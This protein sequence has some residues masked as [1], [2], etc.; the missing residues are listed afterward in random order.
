VSKHPSTE[1]CEILLE[2]IREIQALFLEDSGQYDHTDLT[3]AESVLAD[4]Y[5]ALKCW[6]EIIWFWS[7]FNEVLIDFHIKKYST[8]LNKLINQFNQDY[9]SKNDIEN[10]APQ[11]NKVLEGKQNKSFWQGWTIFNKNNE[12]NNENEKEEKFDTSGTSGQNDDSVEEVIPQVD[13]IDCTLITNRIEELQN[14]KAVDKFDAEIE[15]FFLIS[16]FNHVQKNKLI[17]K[18]NNAFEDL[19]NANHSISL[20]LEITH[21]QYENVLDIKHFKAI[22]VNNSPHMNSPDDSNVPDEKKE[23]DNSGNLKSTQPGWFSLT[24]NASK[25]ILE[26]Q[27]YQKVNLCFNSLSR[28]SDKNFTWEKIDEILEKVEF[29]KIPL[30]RTDSPSSSIN[31]TGVTNQEKFTVQQVVYWNPVETLLSR[32]KKL[33]SVYKELCSARE[34]LNHAENNQKLLKTNTESQ[35]KIATIDQTVNTLESQFM[36]LKDSFKALCKISP[37]KNYNCLFNTEKNETEQ[38]ARNMQKDIQELNK[39]FTALQNQNDQLLTRYRSLKN[40]NEIKKN[41]K[42]EQE[43][44]KKEIENVK[45]EI[46]GLCGK[47]IDLEIELKNKKNSSTKNNSENN[48]LNKMKSNSEDVLRKEIK[49]LEEEIKYKK[50]EHQFK[51]QEKVACI[52]YAELTTTLDTPMVKTFSPF[53]T[54]IQ[55]IEKLVGSTINADKLIDYIQELKKKSQALKGFL[56]KIKDEIMLLYKDSMT[57]LKKLCKR[58]EENF[59]AIFTL[60]EKSLGQ[61]KELSNQCDKLLAQQD[62]LYRMTRQRIQQWEEY[63]SIVDQTIELIS[64]TALQSIE[65]SILGIKG[66]REYFTQCLQDTLGQVNQFESDH[67]EKINNLEKINA[68]LNQ[69]NKREDVEIKQQKQRLKEEGESESDDIFGIVVNNLSP[70]IVLDAINAIKEPNHTDKDDKNK[71]V[72]QNKNNVK[73]TKDVEGT[74][75]DIKNGNP[76]MVGINSYPTG[77]VTT[78]EPIVNFSRQNNGSDSENEFVWENSSNVSDKSFVMLH[79][80]SAV[81]PNNLPTV[82]VDD[83]VLVKDGSEHSLQQQVVLAQK[84]SKRA[85]QLSEKN[86]SELSIFQQFLAGLKWVGGWILFLICCCRHDDARDE[87]NDTTDNPKTPVKPSLNNS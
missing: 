26:N 17:E 5:E 28:L 44:I 53:L 6:K 33:C 62:Y 85:S 10:T 87:S 79:T 86:V 49:K 23:D 78:A 16:I 21:Y 56:L 8:Q 35:N 80:C 71:L 66:T 82:I 65:K 51:E 61:H 37:Y 47:K 77:T 59:K 68:H 30:V 19:F 13:P 18:E 27:C 38:N 52:N 41:V 84:H 69:L 48:T 76:S 20:A 7:G 46:A 36:N 9:L 58:L 75:N 24:W 45:D 32:Y 50:L 40:K 73:D 39:S 1:K 74:V 64:T 81:L 43:T 83:Q 55:A 4:I 60:Q 25:E 15:I 34:K 54:Q 14:K 57:I 11:G 67:Q 2:K 42:Q 12:P 31:R 3:K 70:E 63:H 22:Q 29:Y 72:N